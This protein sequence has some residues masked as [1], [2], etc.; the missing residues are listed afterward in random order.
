MSSPSFAS[1]ASAGESNDPDIP[2][3]IRGTARAS[4]PTFS[5]VTVQGLFILRLTFIAD[6]PRCNE[7]LAPTQ[8]LS[9]LS[10]Y[11][12]PNSRSIL[13]DVTQ[14]K[15]P[16][17]DASPKKRC[18]S[19]PYTLDNSP[20]YDDVSWVSSSNHSHAELSCYDD[21]MEATVLGLQKHSK[22]SHR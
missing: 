3:N 5:M 18:K 14:T 7:A 17:E 8:A 13:C 11:I 12:L 6:H 15:G 22:Q 4:S 20:S 2:S 21:G 1:Q 9:T 16:E 19:S 10:T